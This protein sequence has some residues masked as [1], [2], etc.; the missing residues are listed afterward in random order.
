MLVPEDTMQPKALNAENG[1]VMKALEG[2]EGETDEYPPSIDRTIVAVPEHSA[3]G[4][5][6]SNGK[7]EA[8]VKTL[9]DLVRTLKAAFESRLGGRIPAEHPIR[10]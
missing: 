9:V 10:A 8:S 4:E 5:S 3:P 2:D 7:A 1:Q 6:Q